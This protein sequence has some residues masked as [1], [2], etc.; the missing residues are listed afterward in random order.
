M[1]NNLQKGFAVPAIIAIVAVVLVLGGIVFYANRSQTTDDK[2]TQEKAMM[3]KEAMEQKEKDAMMKADTTETDSMM[4]KDETSMMDKSD[5]MMKAGSYEAYAPEKV[6]LASATHDVVLFFKASWCPTCRAVDADIKAN[7]SKIPGSLAILD[8]N[9]DNSTVLKQK[10][11]VT[12]QH[13]F[14]QV[15]KDGNLIKK[16]SGSPTLS[17]LVS[18]VK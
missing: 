18:E 17:A 13:T 14:V 10:Y 5:T 6:A 11:G 12:Y 9:Y 15:D 16:W 4:K 8:V 2:M 3:E 1:P 7:L